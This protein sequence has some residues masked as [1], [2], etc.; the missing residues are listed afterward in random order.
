MSSTIPSNQ[1]SKFNRSTVIRLLQ[2]ANQIGSYRFTKNLTSEWLE[3]FPGDLAV[4][5]LFAESLVKQKRHE[6]ALPILKRI[7]VS[8]PEYLPTY[9]LLAYSGSTFP[10]GTVNTA[11]ES[12][13][14]LGGNT[15]P[16]DNN[17]EWGTHLRQ[18]VD[19]Q[20]AG[21]FQEAE[22]AFQL[23][24]A[25]NPNTP[26]PAILH[27]KFAYEH[28][29]WKA[30]KDL[31]EKYHTRWPDTL[32]CILI[33]ADTLNKGGNEEDA[34]N[35]LH[36]AS[37]LDIGG[38]VAIRLWGTQHAYQSLVP[39]NPQLMLKTPIP[40]DVASA[41]GWNQLPEGA[42]PQQ[43]EVTNVKQKASSAISHR[44]EISR[45]VA[46]TAKK[47]FT[48]IAAK[49]KIPK[50]ASADA[51]YPVYL[52]ASSKQGLE[53]QYGVE[54]LKL[55]DDALQA[56]ASK[57]R[58]MQGW[59]A[60]II[61]VDDS[62][63]ADQFGLPPAIYN[64]PWAIKK[65][66]TDMDIALGKNGER[67]GA[68]LIVGGDTVIPFHL[69]PNPID[70]FD[71][72]V[73]SDN[74]YACG[75]EN[76]FVPT[77]AV[78]RIPGSA[79]NNPFE[80]V[81]QI[82]H[83]T[84]SR[85]E[86]NNPKKNSVIQT[87]IGHLIFRL[88]KKGQTSNFG[89]SAEV[90][91]RAANAVYR[92]IGKPHQLNVSPPTQSENLTVNKKRTPQL[93]YYNLHGL[94]D[95]AEWYGQKDPVENQSGPEY[96]IALTPKNIHNSGS[97]PVVVFSEAC[98]G[99]NIINK[100]VEEAISLK[101]LDSGSLAVV[102]STCTSYGSLSTPLIAADLL[103]K[104]FWLY[105]KDGYTAGESLRRAKIYLAKEMNNKQGYLDGEDQKTL[106]SFVLYG[107]PLTQIPSPPITAHSKSSYRDYVNPNKIKTVC[108]KHPQSTSEPIPPE[109]IKQVKSVV[110]NYLPGMENA[111]ISLS[112]EHLNCVGHNC[113]T[114]F[115][116][117]KASPKQL[118][119]RKVVTLS[120][121]FIKNEKTHAYHAR[122]TF[123]GEG[124][125]SKLVVSR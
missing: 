49:L 5:Y 10:F 9:R 83:I 97:A 103:G 72:Q 30:L 3:N 41:V 33:Y 69:L 99:A 36:Q 110:K 76:Y 34:V 93:A 7:I 68:L 70:D 63:S 79:S 112:H 74:P 46:A 51:R 89:Y 50:I 96:P 12:I 37:S 77:W 47:E 116:G 43:T 109:I 65:F 8:D 19:H 118:P 107:D 113:P 119:S 32:A 28:Y 123:D 56:L 6:D 81:K 61:Y 85:Q 108:D 35:L 86:N 62:L 98:F 22:T 2:I 39:P 52:I 87:L 18:A 1:P 15:E 114:S 13:Y 102:G 31:A 25:E 122:I 121:Q 29:P 84:N 60:H 73:P 101:F 80:L 57:T 92:P 117:E 44:K 64:D 90:W 40:A 27:L 24:L 106:I 82:K 48:H 124:N 115:L 11:I 104:M 100:K 125:M 58:Q 59:N 42:V 4:E 53:N 88:F 75:D 67:I 78:G 120:K 38:Q 95:T 20:K 94:E 17:I 23:A 16:T 111:N 21:E 105:L 54:S 26:L 66:F 14:A 55:I 91:R 71:T 45:K